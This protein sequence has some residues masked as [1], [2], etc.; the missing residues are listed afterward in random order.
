[1][2]YN[3]TGLTPHTARDWVVNAPVGQRVQFGTRERVLP[4]HMSYYAI[5]EKLT[6]GD[7]LVT[8]CD[9][10]HPPEA[11]RSVSHISVE[12]VAAYMGEPFEN[13]QILPHPISSIIRNLDTYKE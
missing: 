7:W 6:E 2:P 3:T 11:P 12:F 9:S 8:Y 1:M 10:T 13:P 4:D 5:Y